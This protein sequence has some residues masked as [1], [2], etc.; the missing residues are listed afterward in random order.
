MVVQDKQVLID[1]L[2]LKLADQTTMSVSDLKKLI[3]EEVDMFSISHIGELL[4]CTNDG[5]ASRKIM[6]EFCKHKANQGMS[7]DSLYQYCN[8]IKMLLEHCKKELTLMDYTDINLFTEYYRKT[9][10]SEVTV[11]HKFELISSVFTFMMNRKYISEN[12][13]FLADKIKPDTKLK[14]PL[15]QQEIEKIKMVIEKQKPEIA[16]RNMAMVDFMLDTGVR[17][18]ELCNLQLNSVNFDERTVIVFGKER[19]EREVYF[20]DKTK[21]RLMEYIINR[22]DY[23]KN[24]G[25]DN[26]SY[27]F[28]STRGQ[29]KM[30][31]YS[32]QTTIK[33]IGVKAGVSRLH[34]HLLR[35]TMATNLADHNVPIT[36]IAR[37]LGHSDL[38]TINRYVIVSNKSIKEMLDRL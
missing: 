32:I 19:K 36:T 13:M 26:D 28:V 34:P 5:S 1:K 25:I 29:H 2:T 22:K 15:S 37:L 9:G 16:R 27:L 11:L 21:V 7:S 24:N 4:P 14:K 17:V 10:V 23:Q 3:A 8:A 18:S 35:A 20:T 12:P 31:P 33:D 38:S 6:S 30:V